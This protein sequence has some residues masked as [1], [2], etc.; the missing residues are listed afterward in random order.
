MSGVYLRALCGHTIGPF[1]ED[2]ERVIPGRVIACPE[3]GATEAWA[4][5]PEPGPDPVVAPAPGGG[6]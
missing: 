5:S 1:D 6:S 2:D 3:H 4:Q